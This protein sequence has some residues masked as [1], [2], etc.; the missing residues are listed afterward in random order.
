MFKKKYY[1]QWEN[2]IWKSWWTEKSFRRKNAAT[3]YALRM[4]ARNS[5]VSAWRVLEK[6]KTSNP[7]II[8]EGYINRKHRTINSCYFE[9]F[10][11]ED[12]TKYYKEPII[13]DGSKRKNK[14]V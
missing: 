10:S 11:E 1:A 14:D 12:I 3:K 5:N 8:F 4:L 9:D 7:R 6:E 13:I 2:G